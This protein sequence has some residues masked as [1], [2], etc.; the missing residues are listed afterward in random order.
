MICTFVQASKLLFALPSG[1]LK[2]LV[3]FKKNAM[4]GSMC[5]FYWKSM[6]FGYF[7]KKMV[8]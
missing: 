7:R 6:L 1:N 5:F 2:Q 8:D 3:F 4:N